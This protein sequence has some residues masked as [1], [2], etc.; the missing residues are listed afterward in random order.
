MATSLSSNERKAIVPA[1]PKSMSKPKTSFMNRNSGSIVA[2]DPPRVGGNTSKE[3]REGNSGSQRSMDI[4]AK[5]VP[6][7][8]LFR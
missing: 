8:S 4:P 6:Y 7:W 5:P 3:G 2:D 1:T